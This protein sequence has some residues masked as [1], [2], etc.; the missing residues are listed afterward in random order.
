MFD[1]GVKRTTPTVEPVTER[2][3]A[4][5]PRGGR[6]DERGALHPWMRVG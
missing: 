3:S 6:E 1:F 2:C 5:E 4:A